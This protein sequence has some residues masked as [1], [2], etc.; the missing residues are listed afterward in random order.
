MRKILLRLFDVVPQ[1]EANRSVGQKNLEIST[2]KNKVVELSREIKRLETEVLGKDARLHK[3]LKIIDA[4]TGDPAP[5]DEKARFDYTQIAANLYDGILEKKLLHL[6]AVVREEQDTIMLEVPP[7]FSRAQYDFV[8]KGTS[9]AFK[10]L[11]DWG[12]QMRGEHM[13]NIKQ[14]NNE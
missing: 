2:L 12:E 1:G 8:L 6:I 11:M 7:G 10:L 9:N 3:N 14:T 4:T 5:T 13:E